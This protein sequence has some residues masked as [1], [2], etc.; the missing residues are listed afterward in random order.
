MDR[1]NDYDVYLRL[2]KRDKEA[3]EIL[4]DQYERL[5]YS[6]AYRMTGDAK[7]AEDVVQDVFMKLWREHAP[8]SPEKGKF[9]SWL[10]T[11]VRN[12]SLDFHRKKSRQ[13][14]VAYMEH[15][16]EQV[17]VIDAKEE[18]PEHFVE[19]REKQ[20]TIRTAIAELK[21]DQQKIVELFYFQGLSQ[22]V[23]ATKLDIPLGT[24][25][26]RIRLAL[27]HLKK[28]LHGERGILQDGTTNM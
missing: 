11:M 5:L 19:W 13:N 22:D 6:F 18:I 25:K 8:Y 23:I 21:E 2:L 28:K 3:L 15:D 1:Q 10:L 24:V 17:Q 27:G 9:S 14:E 7:H 4:Y 26:S 20:S 16:S 12:T